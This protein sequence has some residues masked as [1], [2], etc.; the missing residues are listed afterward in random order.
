METKI[1]KIKG[2]NVKGLKKNIRVSLKI[3]MVLAYALLIASIISVLS[4]IVYSSAERT[5]ELQTYEA[6]ESIAGQAVKVIESRLNARFDVLESLANRNIIRGVWGDGASTDEQKIQVLKEERK[7]GDFV[8]LGVAD[9]NGKLVTDEGKRIDIS[10]EMFFK[11]AISGQKYVSD[12]QENK[13]SDSMAILFSVPL[14][15]IQGN[16]INGVLIGAVNLKQFNSLIKDITYGDKG[17]AFAV[18]EE[19]TTIAHRD[20]NKVFLKENIIKI[21]QTN[22]ELKDLAEL[23]SKMTKGGKGFGSYVYKG[24]KRLAGYAS[25]QNTGWS[26]AV[27]AP[28]QEVFKDV[29][30]LARKVFNMGVIFIAAA[31]VL[32]L[33]VSSYIVKPIRLAVNHLKIISKGDYTI[34][35]PSGFLKRS[36]EIGE[37]ARAVEELYTDVSTMLSN[38]KQSSFSVQE[39]SEVLSAAAQQ[40]AATS[41][42]VSSTVQ[43]L[44]KGAEQQ[45]ND[46]QDIVG[47]IAEVSASMDEIYENLKMVNSSTETAQQR[48]AR[49]KEDIDTLIASIEDVKKAFEEVSSRVGALTST[50]SQ[51]ETVTG[52]IN[53]ISD[54]T[55]LLALNAAIEAARVGEAGRGFAVVAEEIRK[56]AEQSKTSSLNVGKLVKEVMQETGEVVSTSDNV[57][58]FIDS[59]VNII[60]STI[61]S[62]DDIL[63]TVSDIGPM[64]EQL[65]LCIDETIRSKNVLQQRVENI[66]AVIEEASASAEEIAASSEQISASTQEIASAA[67]DLNSTSYTLIENVKVFKIK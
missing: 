11:K 37:L 44:A 28:E 12:P 35:V 21:S 5:M 57:K 49:G 60:S 26:L 10:G 48:A 53:S 31:I 29:R 7:R 9:I 6:L 45:A 43:E 41:G 33:L 30:M 13:I 19:G 36:D 16:V 14:K 1:K 63:S 27:M 8:F 47:I 56:L 61:Q 24:E 38:V 55:N 65:Y 20:E 23:I 25:V 58:G 59:Q 22:K 39:K 17:Y 42:E 4:Y 50:I 34:D 62:F 2:F 3:K 52:V 32:S 46:V 54:K 40:M 67:Q 51:I 66:S 15:D 18:N 64:I